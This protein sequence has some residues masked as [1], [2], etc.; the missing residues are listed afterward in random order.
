MRSQFVQK[1][2]GFSQRKKGCAQ[3][4]LNAGCVIP[5]CF[6]DRSPVKNLWFSLSVQGFF[7]LFCR[8]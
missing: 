5:V 2:T 1:R 7:P 4:I 3:N 6:A 8:V